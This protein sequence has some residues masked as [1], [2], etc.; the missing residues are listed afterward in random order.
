MRP[1]FPRTSVRRF[2][3]VVGAVSLMLVA[4]AC[5]SAVP[6]RR[7]S[8]GPAGTAADSWHVVLPSPVTHEYAEIQPGDEA[9][10]R[11]DTALA[12]RPD[13]IV[14]G[15]AA[16]WPSPERPSLSETRRLYLNNRPETVVY[17]RSAHERR[18]YRTYAY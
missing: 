14:D 6:H 15:V 7:A 2:V 11:R 13:P 3:S 18:T 17:F 12:L 8:L 4:G 9:Y 1:T 5:G 16:S 10:A